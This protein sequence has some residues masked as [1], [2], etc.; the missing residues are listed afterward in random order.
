MN[1]YRLFSNFK[2]RFFCER[3]KG[4]C[5]IYITGSFINYEVREIYQRALQT[6]GIKD[7]V[8]CELMVEAWDDMLTP[9]PADAGMKGRAFT[10]KGILLLKEIKEKLL[11]YLK[12]QFPDCNHIYIAGYSLAGLFALWSLYE[13]DIFDGAVC[14]SGSLWY[15]A[16]KEYISEHFLNKKSDVYLSLGKKEE[17]TKHFLMKQVGENTRQQYLNLQQDD[18]A[19]MVTLE[20]N[21][22][23]HF[24]DTVERV[25]NGISWMLRQYKKR[26]V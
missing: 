6:S 13:T 12:E 22:G 19:N 9:W 17:K 16:W 11:P 23:G 3:K 2:C 4:P 25:P 10:G 15:P 24:A 8:F 7:Y 1:Q 26:S 14:C 21:E 5:V 18:N 20:W